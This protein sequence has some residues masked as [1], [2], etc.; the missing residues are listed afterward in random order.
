VAGPS[1]AAQDAYL[2]AFTGAL[3][4]LFLVA[5]VVAVVGGVLSM[6]LIRGRDFIGAPER[7]EAGREAVTVEA[8]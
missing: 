8:G 6:A 1:A 5:A 2:Q 3:N 7:S 4:D